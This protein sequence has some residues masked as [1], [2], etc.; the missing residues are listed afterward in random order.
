M[1]TGTSYSRVNSKTA[2]SAV[3]KSAKLLRPLLSKQENR[4]KLICRSLLSKEVA[5]EN[6][7]KE[8]QQAMSDKPELFIDL[9]TVISELP[10]GGSAAAERLREGEYK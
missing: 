7:I 3:T 5:T 9:V 8:L 2:R 10:D 6:P 1:A 4:S